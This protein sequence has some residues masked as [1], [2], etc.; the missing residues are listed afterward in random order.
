MVRI[1]SAVLLLLL[2]TCNF[3]FS[4]TYTF[5]GTNASVINL[6]GGATVS[7]PI[8]GVPAGA[9][10]RQVILKFGDGSEL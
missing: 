9:I 4:Q 1:F 5:S 7:I 3:A 2:L 6:S 8:S 10:L